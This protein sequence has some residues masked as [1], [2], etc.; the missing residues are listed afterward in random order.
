MLLVLL[1]YLPRARLI[2]SIKGVLRGVGPT[3]VCARPTFVSARA[4][5]VSTPARKS[6]HMHLG[7][8]NFQMHAKFGGVKIQRRGRGADGS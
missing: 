6:G 1:D 4:Q 7:T 2:N 5:P 3:F 8:V